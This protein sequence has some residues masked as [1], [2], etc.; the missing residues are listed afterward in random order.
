MYIQYKNQNYEC[1]CTIRKDSIIY[2]NLPTNFPTVISGQI[3]LYANN[4]FELRKDNVEDYLRYTNTNGTLTLTN[5]P[6]PEVI[7]IDDTPSAIEQLR[8]DVDYIAI[9]TGVEL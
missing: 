5:L 1:K 9:M 4:G 7:P 8:A 2:K 3:A 6:E